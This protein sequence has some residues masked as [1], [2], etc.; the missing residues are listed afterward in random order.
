M[1]SLFHFFENVFCPPNLTNLFPPGEIISNITQ[2]ERKS[3][4]DFEYE[5]DEEGE[6]KRDE[7]KTKELQAEHNKSMTAFRT[8][9]MLGKRCV[10][11]RCMI[12]C[13]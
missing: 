8:L 10:C 11:V 1:F 7:E 5:E 9:S 12:V 6:Q 3:Y 13:I 4:Y 2:V